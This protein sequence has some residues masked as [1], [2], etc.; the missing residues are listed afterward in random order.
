MSPHLP[1]SFFGVTM[2]LCVRGCVYLVVYVWHQSQI[3][4]VG[5][6]QPWADEAHAEQRL[7]DVTNRAVVGEADVLSC[8]HE[9]AIARTEKERMRGRGDET[10]SWN[11]A[12]KNKTKQKNLIHLKWGLT[13]PKA[14]SSGRGHGSDRTPLLRW[15]TRNALASAHKHAHV[16]SMNVSGLST[17]SFINLFIFHFVLFRTFHTSLLQISACW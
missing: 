9:S 14:S 1:F 8:G 3:L 2:S 6:K 12:K 11:S 16:Y 10:C 15:R 17:S 13:L 7:H 5:V 4:Q